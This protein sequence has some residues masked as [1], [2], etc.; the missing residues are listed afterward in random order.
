MTALVLHIGT[1]KTGTTSIQEFLARN[2]VALAAQGIHVPE[3]LG[4]TDHR[5]ASYMAED[6]ERVDGFSRELGLAESAALRAA[7]KEEIRVQLVEEV[8]R[9]PWGTWL[10]SSEHFQSRLTTPQE[11]ARL[12][13]ILQ[14][15]FTRI[16]IVIYL[17]N[18]LETAISYWSMRVKGGAPLHSL[19]EPGHFGHHICDHRGILERWLAVFGQQ[20][21]RVRLFAREAFVAGD[22]IR[23]F[24]A[25]TGIAWHPALQHPP[26]LNE[27]MPYAAQR[28]LARVNERVPR[29]IDGRLNPNRPVLGAAFLECFAGQPPYRPSREEQ[30]RYDAFYRDSEDWVRATF[31]PERSRLW[32][33]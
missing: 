32:S 1:E 12:A 30:Q 25:A 17:R 6:V 31:F 10:I 21:I 7:K 27:T 5:W 29:W 13:A 22:L 20:Q 11:V 8:R 16:R 9:Q 4:A 3:F 19:G 23:D 28:L 24:C 18:P 15:L 26:R 33:E 14:P 2:R